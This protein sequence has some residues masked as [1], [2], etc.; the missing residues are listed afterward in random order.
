MGPQMT[1]TGTVLAP[2]GQRSAGRPG[3]P[4]FSAIVPTFSRPHALAACLRALAAQTLSPASF[5]VIVGDDGCAM[6]VSIQHAD[7]LSELNRTV[8]VRVVRQANT[9]PASTRNLAAEAAS[10]RYL[11]FTDDDCEPSPDWLQG[12]Q[13]RFEATP[14]ALLGGGLRNGVPANDGAAATHAI[15]DFVYSEHTRRYGARL[16]STSNLSL[17]AAGFHAIGGFSPEF[18][19][20]A[21]EDYD[22]CWR[23]QESGGNAQ[24][25][26]EAT[27]VHYHELTLSGF[28]RQHFRYGRGLLRVRQRHAARRV[29]HPVPGPWFYMRLV[30]H[31]LRRW[32]N[33]AAWRCAFLIAVAQAATALGAA[34]ELLRP[35][36]PRHTPETSVRAESN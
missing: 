24:F 25:V 16:F 31:P 6:P 35:S 28:V 2:T 13:T 15:M 34:V 33:P 3:A 19:D 32:W 29:Q 4:I 23:W 12:L 22:L 30:L 21:G 18:P 36:R 1:R 5:E 17:P 11:A 20:A 8:S 10:G 7:L 27:V 9:G 14:D 26:P